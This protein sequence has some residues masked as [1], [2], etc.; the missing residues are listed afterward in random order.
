MQN[1]RNSLTKN[2][3]IFFDSAKQMID[4]VK[5]KH[6][7]SV[8]YIKTLPNGGVFFLPPTV[9]TQPRRNLLRIRVCF[10]SI[11]EKEQGTHRLGQAQLH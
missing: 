7:S 4:A 3:C 2:I 11:E 10:G 1:L 9:W 5:L 8:L 6:M